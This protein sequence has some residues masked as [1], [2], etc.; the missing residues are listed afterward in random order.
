MVPWPQLPH[1]STLPPLPTHLGVAGTLAELRQLSEHEASLL[2]LEDSGD[3]RDKSLRDSSAVND[4]PFRSQIQV[5]LRH[6]QVPPGPG[7]GSL[8]GP[9]LVA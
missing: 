9:R 5:R 8:R 6:P 1:Q 2:D 4:K 7:G 3:M